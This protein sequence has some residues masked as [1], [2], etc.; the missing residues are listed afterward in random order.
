MSIFDSLAVSARLPTLSLLAAACG[1][2]ATAPSTAQEPL[3]TIAEKTE[4]ATAMEG[5]FNL[6]WDAAQGVLYWEMD[7]E[8]GERRPSTGASTSWPNRTAGCWWMRRPS[9]C[10]TPAT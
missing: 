3:P 5:F 1:A 4:A 10:A 7:P 8:G 6:Y 9:S 2:F